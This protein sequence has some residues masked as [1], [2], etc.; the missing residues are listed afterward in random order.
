ML[1]EIDERPEIFATVLTARGDYFSA[2]ADVKAAR[3]EGGTAAEIRAFALRRLSEQNLE[4]GRALYHHSKLLIAALNGPAIGLSAAILGHFDFVYAMETAWILTPFSTLAL[5]AEG[6]ASLTFPRRMGISKA[7]EVLIM[8]KKAGAAELQACG[9]FNKL[10]PKS[11]DVEFIQTVVKYL[12]AEFDQNDREAMMISKQ[13]I[14][15]TLA[16]PD[17]SNI[18]EVFA[19]ATRAATGKPAAEFSKMAAK[20]KRHKL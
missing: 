6:G 15:D 20:T 5:V 12:H 7:N 13:L 8:G 3:G 18:R 19:G 1:Y 9:F 14:K 17:A 10:F 11:S 4:L 2:G 16:D